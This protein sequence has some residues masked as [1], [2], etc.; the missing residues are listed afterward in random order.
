MEWERA[1]AAAVA[2]WTRGSKA[3]LN[4]N[5]AISEGLFALSV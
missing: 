1:R 2:A 4:V 5:W 3:A